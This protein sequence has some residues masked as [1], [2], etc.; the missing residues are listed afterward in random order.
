MGDEPM[1]RNFPL[2]DQIGQRIRRRLDTAMY[3]YFPEAVERAL[4]GI[5][6][7]LDKLEAQ[8]AKRGR[9]EMTEQDYRPHIGL[10]GHRRAGKTTL[11]EIVSEG[12]YRHESF[13]DPLRGLLVDLWEPLGLPGRWGVPAPADSY[14]QGALPR[15]VGRPG[16]LHETASGTLVGPLDVLKRYHPEVREAMRAIG[17]A[18]RAALPGAFVDAMRPKLDAGDPVI[19]DDVRFLDEAELIRQK[20]GV[21]V[22]VRRPEGTTR[23]PETLNLLDAVEP[24]IRLYNTGSLEDLQ[25]MAERLTGDVT[26]VVDETPDEF[27]AGLSAAQTR[28][29]RPDRRTGNDRRG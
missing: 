14:I 25:L 4:A 3:S 22:H 26:V 23:D 6:E 9:D 12:G 19:V 16:A 7:D 24:D 5:H 17:A 27:A 18:V 2:I 15:W 29:V 13:A 8:V 1:R 28:V 10:I 21:L 11:A 20:G